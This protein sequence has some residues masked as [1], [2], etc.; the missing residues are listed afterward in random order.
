MEANRNELIALC[1]VE[2]GKGLQDGI[3]EVREA[4]DFAA[5]MRKKRA[6]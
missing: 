2:A 5:T 6:N 3:D 1:S 4:V